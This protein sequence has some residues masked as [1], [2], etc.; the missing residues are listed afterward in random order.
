MNDRNGSTPPRRRKNDE[1][2]AREW[3][4]EDEVEQLRKAAAKM[5]TWGHRN[6]TMILIGF[7][8]GLRVSELIE[9]RWE[10][11][12]LDARTLFVRR[13]KGSKSSQHTLERD[14]VAALRKLG[15]ERTGVVFLSERR[16]PLSR[17]TFSHVM[18]EAGLAAKLKITVHPHMLRHA[19][20]YCLTAAGHPTRMVQEWLGHRN[21]QHTVRYT[22]LDPERFRQ[23]GMWSKRAR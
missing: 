14:E 18:A 7:R 8:H 4:K 21:I 19:C 20:G 2:R 15:P 23:A 22:E 11:I 17:R 16:A 9:L 12:D 3:L 6:A 10:Q 1:A 5:G 13:L